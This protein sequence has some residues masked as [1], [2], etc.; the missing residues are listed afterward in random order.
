MSRYRLRFLLQEIDLPRGDTIIGRS[1][2]CQVTLEDPLVSRQHARIRVTGD[3]ATVEDLGSRN[4]VLVNG[5]MVTGRQSLVDGDRIR[6]GTQEVVFFAATSA[7]TKEA[8]AA[9]PTGFL[10]H[11]A[12]C[13][14]PYATEL[15]SCPSCGSG[16]RADEDTITGISSSR[17]R[18]WA[19]ELLL[20]VLERAVSLERWDEVERTLGRARANVDERLASGQTVGREEL[21]AL[22]GPAGKLAL[23]Q[24]RGEWA[25]WLFGVYRHVGFMPSARLSLLLSTLPPV[26]LA[27]LLPEATRVVEHVRAQGGPSPDDAEAFSELLSLTAGGRGEG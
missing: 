27:T 24:Q 10:C 6:I 18:D 8:H 1:S 20:E 12:G 3:A 23:Q 22:A 15:G 17:A 19:L 13:G 5:R 11:C 7:D 4:G 16:A 14:L 9:R 25:A 2:S 26:A 21:D